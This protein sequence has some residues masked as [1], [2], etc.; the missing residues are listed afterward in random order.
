MNLVN[1]L[2]RATIFRQGAWICRGGISVLV[3]L[4]RSGTCKCRC[5]EHWQER[6]LPLLIF[7]AHLLFLP[8]FVNAT[9]IR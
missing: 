7:P 1:S 5:A 3:C 9:D 6:V 2:I 8:K 4:E